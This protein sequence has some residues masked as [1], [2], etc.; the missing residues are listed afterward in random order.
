MFADKERIKKYILDSGIKR[1]VLLEDFVG[2]GG[3]VSETLAFVESL[4]LGIDVIVVPLVICPKGDEKISGMLKGSVTMSYKPVLRIPSSEIFTVDESVDENTC[5]TEVRAIN[6]EYS[7]RMGL[8][9]NVDDAE[10]I[11]IGTFGYKNTGALIVMYSNCPNNTLA[12]IH[13][14]NDDNWK[15]L[16]PRSERFK[17]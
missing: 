14:S 7:N 11:K 2:S 9:F 5:I 10:K 13:R 16:F 3:Q 6:A 12:L 15:P 8:D 4:E 17:I 1:L